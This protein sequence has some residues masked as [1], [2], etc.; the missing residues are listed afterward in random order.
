M[1]KWLLFLA[2]LLP[3]RAEESPATLLHRALNALRGPP[4]EA[5]LW[6]TV[7]R[8]SGT[9]RYRIW[10]YTDGDRRSLFRVLAPARMQNQGFLVDGNRIWIYDP[11]FRRTL[12]LPPSGK[13]Q[14]FLGS[15]LAFED[16]AGR[17]LEQDYRVALGGREE[18][19]IVLVLTP[20]PEAPTPYG[21]LE[22]V[23]EAS[24]GAPIAF[25]YYDQRGRAVKRVRFTAKTAVAP[26]RYLITQGV[27]EDLL[28][29][30]WATAFA[31]K[32]VRPL[33]SVD[34]ACFT[35]AALERGC[36]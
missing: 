33:K 20:R 22:V 34:P 35:L 28:H 29:P 4:M 11:R 23:L 9:S 24:T 14:R 18:G 8:P 17:G 5:E 36:R 1:T 27:V 10:L 31:L 12:E 16:L 21:R 15:D 19:R 7:E 3:L 32:G 25:I 26:G 13:G 6:L 30:G 2:L